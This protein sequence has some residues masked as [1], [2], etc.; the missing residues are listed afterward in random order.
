MRFYCNINKS[1]EQ[2]F[3]QASMKMKIKGHMCRNMQEASVSPVSVSV[4]AG[5]M[6][7]W[8]ATVGPKMNSVWI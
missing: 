6:N 5:M 3:F 4:S 7:W 2:L 1:L 8:P